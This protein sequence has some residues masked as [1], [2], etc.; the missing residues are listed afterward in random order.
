MQTY[1]NMGMFFHTF[2][3]TLND[4]ILLTIFKKTESGDK[5]ISH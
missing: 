4:F 1:T 3:S 2:E 5:I